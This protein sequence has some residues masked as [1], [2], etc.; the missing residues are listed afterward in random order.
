MGE[1]G[2][3]YQASGEEWE[4]MLIGE[5]RHTIDDKRRLAIPVSFRQEL[6]KKVILTR[7]LDNCLFVYPLTAWAKVAE[8][9]GRLPLGAA[10]TRSFTRFILAGAMESEVDAMGRVLVPDFL[11]DFA[12]LKTRVVVA[13]L[14]DRLEIWDEKRW[15][16]HIDILEKQA[17]SLAEKLGEVGLV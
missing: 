8:K 14:H 2:I 11:Q 17:D 5:Y 9:L 6:G 10:S 12:R 15:R 16:E 4:I 13:G 3:E 7:G 1:S